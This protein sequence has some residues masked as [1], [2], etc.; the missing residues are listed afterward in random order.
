MCL[1]A[2][3]LSEKQRKSH[4]ERL[5]SSG[6]VSR[7]EENRIKEEEIVDWTNRRHIMTDIIRR[8]DS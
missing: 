2:T 1:L 4:L 8:L 3:S 6:C 5:G 7:A